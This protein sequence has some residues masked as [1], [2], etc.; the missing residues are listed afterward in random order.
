MVLALAK[1]EASFIC[2]GPRHLLTSLPALYATLPEPSEPCPPAAT[3]SSSLAAGR[4][5]RRSAALP[6]LQGCSWAGLACWVVR[7]VALVPGLL[8][9]AGEV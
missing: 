4:Q 5:Q 6:R 8:G 2:A 7:Q 1:K 9:W 3:P